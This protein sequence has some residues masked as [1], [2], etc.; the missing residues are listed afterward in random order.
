MR[1]IQEISDDINNAF[2]HVMEVILDEG[3]DGYISRF[4]SATKAQE[5]FEEEL[6]DCVISSYKGHEKFSKD[7][8]YEIYDLTYSNTQEYARSRLLLPE[9]F[10]KNMAV[11]EKAY[12]D[13]FNAN[14]N[15]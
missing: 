14:N 12:L 8:L 4:E 9:D 11:V 13:G 5:A 2:G 1:S 7:V 10:N 3:K 6:R 15:K